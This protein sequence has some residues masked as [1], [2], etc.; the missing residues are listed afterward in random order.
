M[1][2]SENLQKPNKKMAEQLTLDPSKPINEQNIKQPFSLKSM[3]RNMLQKEYPS[4]PESQASSQA[5]ESFKFANIDFHT[6]K[7]KKMIYTIFRRNALAFKSV[8]TKAAIAIPSIKFKYNNDKERN[9]V[10]LF[11]QNLHPSS[12]LLQLTVFLR[13]LYIDTTA[14]G[15]GFLDPIW[16]KK[17]NTIE[18]LKKIH[19]IE[20]DLLR[21]S[22]FGEGGEVKLDRKGNPV[23][24]VQR[25]NNKTKQIPFCRVGF[26]TF[27]TIGDEWLGIS[28]LEPVYQNVWRLMNIEEGIATAIFR[29]GFPL[30][31]IKV[32]GASEGR[33]PTKE[34]LVA[35]AE[36]VK[37][38]N[39]KS[40]FVH[41]PNYMVKLL[42]SFSIGKSSDYVEPFIDQIVAMSDLPKFILL[43]SSDQ[44]GQAT[45]SELIKFIKPLLQPSKDK[46]KLFFEEQILQPLMVANNIET[47]PQLII[48][49]LPLLEA[50][51]E[52]EIVEKPSVESSVKKTDENES[53][54]EEKKSVPA[55]A[56][57]PNN[58]NGLNL[59]NGKNLINGETKQLAFSAKEEKK[60]KKFVGKETDIYEEGKAIGKIKLREPRKIN[61]NEFIDLEYAHKIMG[62]ERESRWPGETD[63][64]VY[65]FD[66]IEKPGD[67]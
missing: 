56:S 9:A 22:A 65:E 25:I 47:V 14:F 46:L 19:P 45:S 62:D 6:E 27:N 35:A 54:K 67:K 11:L 64:L 37:G 7:G 30:Y 52:A 38:L 34:Q 61:L 21:E 43:G 44:V 3:F 20:M 55:P 50:E 29:H 32:S 18:G 42:E 1:R 2:D 4:K 16:N 15:T 66:I 33:P 28:D 26:L 12:G 57:S 23:G 10:E 48:G 36:E 59:E 40:E 53:L 58:I 51:I 39:Y 63:F 13:D 49:D 60:I 41:G 31:D 8:K 5:L 24:W 17:R